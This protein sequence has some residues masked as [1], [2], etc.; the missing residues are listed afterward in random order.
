MPP[1]ERRCRPGWALSEIDSRD[2]VVDRPPSRWAVRTHDVE[3][4]RNEVTLEPG[5]VAG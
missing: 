5:L 1:P 2:H 4:L 3:A